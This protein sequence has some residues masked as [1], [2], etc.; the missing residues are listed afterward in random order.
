MTWHLQN[1]GPCHHTLLATY[2]M[3]RSLSEAQVLIERW[4]RHYKA[5]RPHSSLGYHSPVPESMMP[6]DQ[7]PTMHS[8]SN[9]TTRWGHSKRAALLIEKA[10]LAV[11][12]HMGDPKHLCHVAQRYFVQESREDGAGL[13]SLLVTTR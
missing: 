1:E 4:R 6:I 8:H 11:Y 12:M 9:W 13:V 3:T 5:V 7:R 2:R 10:D